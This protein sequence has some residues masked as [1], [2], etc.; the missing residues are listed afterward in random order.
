MVKGAQIMDVD[1]LNL[2]RQQRIGKSQNN[3]SLSSAACKMTIQQPINQPLEHY[4]IYRL[5]YEKTVNFVR[6]QR[7]FYL[8]CAYGFKL[9]QTILT[10]MKLG[11]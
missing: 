10:L 1:G 6:R 8:C 7:T 4:A 2:K 11:T 3:M 9:N 5:C